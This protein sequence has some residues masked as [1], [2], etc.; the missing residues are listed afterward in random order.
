MSNI[1]IAIYAVCKN[2]VKHVKRFMASTEGADAVY[3]TDTGSDDGTVE[4]LR[5]AGAVVNEHRVNWADW[6]EK[7]RD[8]WK[9]KLDRPWRFDIARNK[10]M[11]EIPKDFDWCI[12]LDLDEVLHPGWR[13]HLEQAVKENPSA[14]RMRYR[15]I[16]SHHANGTPDVEYWG[17]KIHKRL[18]YRWHHPVH[19]V[20]AYIGKDKEVQQFCNLVIEHFPDSA[21]SRGQYFPLLE[22]AVWED[23]HDDRN[24]HY[25]GREYFFHSHWEKA[26]AELQRHISLPRAQWKAERARSMQYIAKC[27]LNLKDGDG[28]LAWLRRACAEDPNSREPWLDLAQAEF[29]RK[30][31]L[32]GYYAAKQA[33]KITQ[34]VQVYM[35]NS[36]VWSEWPHDLAG[37]CACYVGLLDEARFH[38]WEAFLLAPHDQRIIANMKFVYREEKGMIPRIKPKYY[39]INS[40]GKWQENAADAEQVE[41]LTDRD[42]QFGKPG[43]VIIVANND[44]DPPKKWD[45]LLYDT[46]TNFA[47]CVL[48]KIGSETVFAFDFGC[49]VRCSDT[50]ELAMERLRAEQLIKEVDGKI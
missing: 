23:P 14:T 16:W 19:E 9:S 39:I 36:R 2:E 17:D 49:W 4:A 32:G 44:L 37:T 8:H 18:D 48:F 28:H 38:T 29:D 50:S 27:C 45:Q 21:K 47:G 24:S 1:K 25:L 20:M 6:P 34:R 12:C 7:S 3:V 46:F 11:F 13:E 15:Y 31:Y 41:I 43:D 26:K 22:L 42:G 10:S 30:D 5:S 40:K 33:L 35:T